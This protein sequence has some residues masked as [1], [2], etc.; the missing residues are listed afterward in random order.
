MRADFA[1]D[2]FDSVAETITNQP[3]RVGAL[4]KNAHTH[5]ILADRLA[6]YVIEIHNLAIRRGTKT[7]RAS[8]LE[9]CQHLRQHHGPDRLHRHGSARLMAAGANAIYIRSL[10]SRFV[11]FVIYRH[12]LIFW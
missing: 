2:G 3:F 7:V 11:H 9:D 5:C 4:L 6:G 10:V 1:F 8:F 12:G